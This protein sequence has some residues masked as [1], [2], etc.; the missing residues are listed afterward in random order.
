MGNMS[1]QVLQR[2]AHGAKRP[3]GFGAGRYSCCNAIDGGV[4]PTGSRATGEG[5]WAHEVTTA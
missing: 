2:F 5:I 1:A 4:L 3:R